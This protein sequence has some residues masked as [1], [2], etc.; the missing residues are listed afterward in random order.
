MVSVIVPVYNVEKYLEECVESILEQTYTDFELILVDDGS[1]D[2]SGAICDSIADRDDRIRV[3]HKTNGGL[4]DARNYGIR[5]SKGEYLTFI[6]SDD[7]V[8]Q[9]YLDTLVN[10]INRYSVSM[11]CVGLCL[12]KS[13]KGCRNEKV[14]ED[15]RCVSSEELLKKCCIREALGISAPGKLYHK[16]LF[17][18]IS[19]PIGKLYEDLMTTPYIIA[20]CDKIAYSRQKLYFYYQREDSIM[21]HSIGE[22]DLELFGGL[23]ELVKFVDKNYP[24]LHEA[25]VCRYIDDSFGTIIQRLIYNNDYCEKAKWI[26]K[27]SAQYFWEGL[28][29]KYIGKGKK[30]QLILFLINSRIYRFVYKIFKKIK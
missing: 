16:S 14:K 3:F 15:G 11:S 4:S 10:L 22:K 20:L 9:Y 24:R 2:K 21:H 7:Y 8:S 23:N 13:R 30:I 18:E 5:K 26:K 25:A 1:S 27:I 28:T 19:Y 17:L 12:T 29:N 6:D